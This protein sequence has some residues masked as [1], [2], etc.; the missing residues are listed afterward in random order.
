[1]HLLGRHLVFK[2]ERGATVREV[3]RGSEGVPI[4]H[5]F[6]QPSA[7]GV[8]LSCGRYACRRGR[9]HA[10]PAAARLLPVLQL[11]EHARCGASAFA[12]T[13]CLHADA[14]TCSHGSAYA[15]VGRLHA[16]RLPDDHK[17][18]AGW[19]PLARL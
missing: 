6:P 11:C 7:H 14:V 1:M 2:D 12:I 13:T 15:R 10:H 19:R 18:A 9:L 4:A 5:C 16:W 8:L 17:A 3:P